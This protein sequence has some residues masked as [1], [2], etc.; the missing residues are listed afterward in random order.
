MHHD[1]RFFPEPEASV[2]ARHAYLPFG[3][4]PRQCLG[5]GLAWME[6]ILMLATLAQTWR[7]QLVPGP[8][9]APWGLATLQPK[10]GIPVRLARR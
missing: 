7:M 3:G 4:G 8:P 6:G 2:P 5:E 10:Q 1:A 9:V